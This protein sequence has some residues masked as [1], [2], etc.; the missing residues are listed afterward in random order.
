MLTCCSW[1]KII[2]L[3]TFCSLTSSRSIA[4]LWQQTPVVSWTEKRVSCAKK[5]AM[6]NP[7]FMGFSWCDSHLH[8]TVS[9]LCTDTAPAPTPSVTV[10]WL[11]TGFNIAAAELALNIFSSPPY[12]KWASNYHHLQIDNEVTTLASIITPKASSFFCCM[13]KLIFKIR[14]AHFP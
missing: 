13:Q 7:Y 11:P 12:C 10:G 1:W 14:L 3:R 2:I 4:C 9:V 6:T 8:M 5:L